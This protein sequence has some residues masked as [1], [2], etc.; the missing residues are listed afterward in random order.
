MTTTTLNTMLSED[1]LS[2]LLWLVDNYG[3]KLTE[4]HDYITEKNIAELATTLAA[5]LNE[6]G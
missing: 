5:M 1:N 4:T 2:D 3:Q 6:I